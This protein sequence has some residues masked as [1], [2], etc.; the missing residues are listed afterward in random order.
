ML[1]RLTSPTWSFQPFF[2]WPGSKLGEFFIRWILWCVRFSWIPHTTS[3]QL[4]EGRNFLEVLRRPRLFEPWQF[5]LARV[6][7]DLQWLAAESFAPDSYCSWSDQKLNNPEARVTI[8]E[9]FPIASYLQWK[10]K[11]YS[12]LWSIFLA[13]R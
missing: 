13:N 10:V 7:L 9:W 11:V 12:V 2:A 8:L 4:R 1:Q 5:K 3:N 6:A